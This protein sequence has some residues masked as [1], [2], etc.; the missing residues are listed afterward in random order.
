MAGTSAPRRG[1]AATELALF[2][3]PGTGRNAQW[4]LRLAESG[5]RIGIEETAQASLIRYKQAAY[6]MLLTIRTGCK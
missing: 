3:P 6:P 1:K 4:Y 2:H 5:D